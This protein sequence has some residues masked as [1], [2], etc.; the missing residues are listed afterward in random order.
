MGGGRNKREMEG[1]REGKKEEKRERENMR[2]RMKMFGPSNVLEFAAYPKN[3]HGERAPSAG[4]MQEIQEL[5]FLTK[6]KFKLQRW[7]N[8]YIGKELH[9]TFNKSAL[10]S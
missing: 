1:G 2:I 8:Y 5:L 3:I 6:I 4:H 9:S 10:V 7:M